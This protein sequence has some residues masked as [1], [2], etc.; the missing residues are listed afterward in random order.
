MSGALMLMLAV[1]AAEP[2][3]A[4][5]WVSPYDYP[6]AA[7]K[8]KRSGAS[9]FILRVSAEGRPLSCEISGSSGSQDLDQQT[10]AM[11]MRRA[12]FKPARDAAGRAM[13]SVYR[14]RNSWWAGDGQPPAVP[15]MR[16]DLELSV[17]ELPPGVEDPA[18]VDVAFLVEANGSLSDCTALP[19]D[20]PAKPGSKKGKAQRKA[21][22]LLGPTAC[23]QAASSKLKP[24][25]DDSGSAVPSIQ[26]VKVAFAADTA[27]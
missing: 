7:L 3:A 24:F 8:E 20:P 18:R 11:V 16:L 5:D 13:P 15:P 19:P 4:G 17:A 22:E 1:V 25:V 14:N 2:I 23:A 9:E 12:R 10:C 27:S 21:V 26:I 6:V